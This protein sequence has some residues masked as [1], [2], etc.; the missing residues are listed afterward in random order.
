MSDVVK[1]SKFLSLILRHKP[2]EVDITLDKHGWANVDDIC[3]LANFTK[4]ELNEVV[5]TNNKKRF[6]YNE[7]K[8]KIRACQ[9][10]SIPIDLNLDPV[11]PPPFLYH[12]TATRFLNAIKKEGLKAGSRMYVHLSNDNK[13]A[14]NVGSRHGQPFVITVDS[15]SMHRDG[16]KFYLST[17]KV[18]LTKEVPT[19]YLRLERQS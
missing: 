16:Y 12:G 15:F 1:K 9:G 10:H 6:E 11:M 5:T 17:N 4:D 2:E 13:T 8:T 14:E 19:K 3:K 7:N 18:W